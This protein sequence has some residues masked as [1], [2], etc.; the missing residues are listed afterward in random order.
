[1]GTGKVSNN[2]NDVSSSFA[3]RIYGEINLNINHQIGFNLLNNYDRFKFSFQLKKTQIHI[4]F[5][6]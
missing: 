6:C 1:M 3:T 4:E 2:A 5:F